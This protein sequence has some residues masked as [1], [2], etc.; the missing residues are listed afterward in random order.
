[1]NRTPEA[2]CICVSEGCAVVLKLFWN[3]AST[4]TR[5]AIKVPNVMSLGCG[6]CS[7]NVFPGFSFRVQRGQVSRPLFMFPKADGATAST[8]S[9]SLIL[10]QQWN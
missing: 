8:R 6:N 9:S 5:W 4:E 10:L 7:L 2:R 1:M 3:D